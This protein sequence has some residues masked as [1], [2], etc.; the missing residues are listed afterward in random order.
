VFFLDCLGPSCREY[1]PNNCANN[2]CNFV[3]ICTDGCEDGWTGDQC[4]TRMYWLFSFF[5]HLVDNSVDK[6]DRL[7][8]S[9]NQGLITHILY[10]FVLIKHV[11]RYSLFT[12]PLNATVWYFKIPKN[13]QI[14]FHITFSKFFTLII[15][16]QFNTVEIFIMD[17][18]D[19]RWGSVVLDSLGFWIL[20]YFVYNTLSL[21][22]KLVKE[23]L[24]YLII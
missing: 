7:L 2:N 8:E 12:Q 23:S 11:N 13:C 21:T 4:E 17:S 19:I 5:L 22:H 1:C 15:M 6:R 20:L 9:Y 24:P 16:I 14:L 18:D 10:I 3:K